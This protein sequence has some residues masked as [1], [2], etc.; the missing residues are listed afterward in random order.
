MA[1]SFVGASATYL[2]ASPTIYVPPGLLQGDMLIIVTTGSATPTTP[3]GWTQKS[4]QGANQFVTVLYKFATGTETT[5]SL[6]IA[7]ATSTSVMLA[8]RGADNIDTVST[9]ATASAATTVAT[10]TLSTTLANEYV[11]SVFAG[12]AAAGTWTAPGSTTTR[13]NSAATASNLGLLLVDE[14]QAASGTSTSRT[15]TITNSHNLTGFSFSLVSSN[16][17]YWVG[18]TGSWTTSSTTNWAATSGGAAG[19]NVPT[20]INNVYFDQAGTYTV[21]LT[22]A[23]T[24]NDFTVSAGTVTL[25][26]TGTP[27]IS[28]SM[29]LVA[30]TVWSATGVI[31]FNSNAPGKTITTN[32]VTINGLIALSGVGGAWTLGSALTATNLLQLL[33]GT[34]SASTYNVTIGGF[35]SAVTNYRTLNMGSGTWTLTAAGNVW[36]CTTATRLTLNAQTANIVLSDTSTTARTFAGGGQI[37]NKLTIGGTTGISNTTLTGSAYFSEI[38]STK[39]VAHTVTLTGGTGN[40]IQCNVWSITGTAGN[41][42]TLTG[43]STGYLSVVTRPST[44]NYIAATNINAIQA[45]LFL[46]TGSSVTTC[47]NVL[48][49]AY[50][51]PFTHYWRG[52]TGTWDGT[53]TTNWSASSGGS[54]GS[55]VPYGDED[56]IFDSASNATAYT[57]TIT[58]SNTSYTARCKN[59][60]LNA[61]ASGNLSITGSASAYTSAYISIF[62]S[63]SVASSNVVLSSG[64]T[65][66]GFNF[67]S[68][69]SGNTIN[70]GA[71]SLSTSYIGTDFTGI[72]GVWTLNNNYIVAN[73]TLSALST[74]TA[75]TLNT[76]GYTITFGGSFASTGDIPRTLN[77]GS[78]VV[79]VGTTT[80]SYTFTFSGS[81]LTF[82]PGTS[83]VNA[84]TIAGNGA[85]FYALGNGGGILNAIG[86][87]DSCQYLIGTGPAAAG[88]SIINITR[89]MPLVGFQ[90]TGTA[91]NRRVLFKSSTANTQ[92]T[93]TLTGASSLTDADFKDIAVTGASVSGTRVGDR[94]NNSGITFDAAKTVYWNQATGGNWS[95]TNW[96]LS[97]GGSV[98]N[99]NFP[100]PQDTATIG[101][102]GLNTSATVTLDPAMTV[103]TTSGLATSGVDMSGRTNAMTL[104]CTA[105]PTVFGNWTNGSGTTLFG[106][107][108]IT[109]G[110]RNTQTITSAGK[111]FTQPITIDSVG[112]T[113]QLGD[114]FNNGAN[115]VTVTNG[116]F[117]TQNYN[118]TIGTL[119]SSNSNLRT[120]TLGS[121]TVTISSGITFT[122][123]T[124]LTFN[125][126]TSQ[127]NMSGTLSGG[128][129]FTFYNVS[130]T[131]TSGNGSI[132]GP[133]TFNN[134]NIA[135]RTA[136][137]GLG[138]FAF[139][140]NQIING[141]LTIS[142]GTN[143]TYRIFITSNTTYTART[144]TCAAV[145]SLTDI[146]FQDIIIAGPAAPVSGTRL[147]DCKGNSGITFVAGKTVYWNLA[148][149]QNWSAT[150]WALTST[151]AP[152]VNNFPLAQDTATFT[153]AGSVT[154]TISF[155]A[156]WNVGTIDMSGRTSAMTL[157]TSGTVPIIYGNWSSGTGTTIAGS[158]NLYFSG[159]SSQSIT[160]NG[161]TFTQYFIFDSLGGTVTLQDA[162]NCNSSSGFN[163][164]NGTLDLNGKT[165]TL[166]SMAVGAGTKNITFNGGTIVLTGSGTPFNNAGPTGFTTT[167]GTG[168]GTISMTSASAK[169]FAGG[170][171]VYNCVIN[172]GGAGALTI[173]GNNYFQDITNTYS[174]T[175]A[176]TIT[177]TAGTTQSCLSFSATGAVGNVLTLNTTSSTATLNVYNRPSATN[178]VAATNI[179]AS[180]APIYLGT[181][182]TATTCTNVFA[183]AYVAPFTH[184]WRG[185]SGTWDTTTTTNW[186]TSSG[187][188]G[189]AAVPWPDENVVFDQAATY[190]VTCTGALVCRDITV[191]AG[192]VTFA[193]GTSPTFAISGSMSLAAATVWSSTG[194]ITFNSIATG[195]TI[196]SN[197]V[198]ISSPIT[199][200]GI[201]G[202]WTLGSALTF[203]STI[204]FTNGT[205]S[206][207]GSNYAITG[208]GSSSTFTIGG[209]TVSLN[210]S[211]Y[212]SSSFTPFTYSSGT[213]NAGTSQ[214]NLIAGPTTINGSS[215]FYNVNISHSSA[216][217]LSNPNTFNNLTI[218][219]SGVVGIQ[220]ITVSAN[221][222]VNGTLT[223]N[224][225][226]TGPT[227]RQFIV[228]NSS[229]SSTALGSPKTIT[230]ATVSLTN[231]DFLDIT[232]AGA[233]IPWTGTNLGDC[234]GNTNITFPAGKTVYW[235][236]AGAQSWQAT[237][238]ATSSGGTPAAANFPLA[239]D[240]AVFDNT[241]SVTG[242]IS[243]DRQWPT[244]TIDMSARTNA[245]TFS[246]SGGLLLTGDLLLGSGVNFIISAS[247]FYF[248]G[249]TL[250]RLNLLGSNCA[251][252]LYVNSPSGT[253]QIQSSF[254]LKSASVQM[255]A[256]TFDL[257]G[258]TLTIDSGYT[259]TAT[260]TSPMNLTFNGGTIICYGSV[261]TNV[262]A[263]V[264]T[265]TAGTGTGTIR[266][267]GTTAHT[268]TAGGSTYNCTIDQGGLGALTI[269]ANNSTINNITNT[270]NATGPAT[271]IF[272]NTTT[273]TFNNWNASGTAGNP[274]VIYSNSQGGRYL[275]NKT[276]GTV[277]ADYLTLYD[278]YATGGA[279]WNAGTN[280]TNAA[281]NQG[282]YSWF[283]TGGGNV[284]S[285]VL[286]ETTSATDAVST[287]VFLVS[288]ITET[289]TATDAVDAPGSTYNPSLSETATATDALSSVLTLLAQV[290]ETATGTDT[291]STTFLISSN[292]AETATA[293]DATASQFAFAGIIF[294]TATATDTT[295]TANN[296]FNPVT[297]ETATG[298]DAISTKYTTNPSVAETATATDVQSAKYVANPSVAETATG[299]DS[300]IGGLSLNSSLAETA[301]GTDSLS[302]Q[303]AFSPFIAET[304][305]ATDATATANNTF[306]PSFAETATATDATSTANNIFK[307]SVAETATA[308]DSP[309]ANRTT[310]GAIAETAT[311]TDTTQSVVIFVGA[312]SETATASDLIS[313]LGTFLS[314]IAETGTVTDVTLVAPSVFKPQVQEAITAIDSPASNGVLN[315][316]FVDSATALD[317]VIG[318]YLWNV[319]D[320]SQTAN[321]QNINNAQSSGW[322]VIDISQ[323]PGWTPIDT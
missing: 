176:T 283:F 314:R 299:T 64:S 166:I 250:Q 272:T 66:L 151:G 162:F 282:Y 31:T 196:T 159:R 32:G 93:L 305:T 193:D 131:N 141:T 129:G 123:S 15:G 254:A 280:S 312:V 25:S 119:S 111:T 40:I 290:A 28:G 128:N 260:G 231:C 253:L 274:L 256:G 153:N 20:A 27:T 50:V 101:N 289:A 226:S 275:L 48:A 236:L 264:F 184:Y 213:F 246:S 136:S 218:A 161:S 54:G 106:S 167:A 279:T 2:G 34:F 168:T 210:G 145:S 248:I 116:T 99:D 255:Y 172:Q 107:G 259:F 73:N 113:V 221:Q 295:L 200:N 209:G 121:S 36:V 33:N 79:S 138:G 163:F 24:C 56:V 90:T 251:S 135:G 80:S 6:T 217:T 225:N 105:S 277:S 146:D 297:A 262:G 191:S 285:G 41:V 244:K 237:G 230:A 14:L 55:A 9:F 108:T 68:N 126:G 158:N 269:S 148:G 115:A 61:P 233:S 74:H 11:V 177:L 51:A 160:S 143:A 270:Y 195:K 222:T 104:T 67:A 205:F 214:I 281:N 188:S 63:L 215:T 263:S 4:A 300:L 155:D 13:V 133:N 173:S 18:G 247:Q 3:T 94:K 267:A 43:V 271:I 183:S 243:I 227:Q 154:G 81:N 309:A 140:A 95:G 239:Q 114:A 12:S 78:S 110:G 171:F 308:T 207:S 268:L 240:T 307:P 62:G 165:I 316:A 164:A 96:A 187:G 5:Q 321:W 124:N 258:Y 178:Y 157:D 318:A 59:L 1:V 206:T 174:A 17:R 85:Q 72:N 87:T 91:G 220:S 170:S 29:S 304:A 317:S 118:A 310:T 134:L 39:T 179:I 38:A 58:S 293:T 186:S 238:W 83:T 21:T 245:M 149:A 294:E 306:N 323:N 190:T 144:L 288:S 45:P 232:A 284:Y 169:T 156:N 117:I 127:I 19:A 46:G 296:T 102:T 182:S 235:N 291:V 65:I 103:S 261:T 202:S 315:A 30:G 122:T 219:S 185:G 8:Y 180:M 212:T 175:G 273:T 49:S 252:A 139:G 292:I 199:F 137:A 60:T 152:S 242:T 319:I 241:G 88:V 223:L 53:T 265:T 23:L 228:G 322:T 69:V 52:G 35:S 142:A 42:V 257:N 301:T 44:L 10:N 234:K 203:S 320:D 197:N 194:A 57:V 130:F 224:N 204:T 70:L 22:G 7:G 150:G 92:R 77:F 198:S 287:L 229:Y 109:F 125:S 98:S 278:S 120:I 266:F 26:S 47:T 189:G 82:T 76:A 311:A 100:L 192:T 97:S 71:L 303:G 89:D 302:S 249:R 208:S 216:V 276:S 16:N 147:G 313:S 84:Y 37:Y 286:L 298:T 75:G 201:N 112:G 86:A 181:G 132:L 211:T